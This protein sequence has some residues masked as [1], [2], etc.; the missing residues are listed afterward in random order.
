VLLE[1]S[2]NLEL[3]RR[4]KGSLVQVHMTVTSEGYV[5]VYLDGATLPDFFSLEH[6]DAYWHA[7]ELIDGRG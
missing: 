2:Y 4:S 6:D 3:Y 7:C 1:D 5:C